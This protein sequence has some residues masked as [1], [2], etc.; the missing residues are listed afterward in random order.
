MRRAREEERCGS[1]ASSG[2]RGLGWGAAHMG[3]AKPWTL[4]TTGGDGC[5]LELWA[6]RWSVG[7]GNVGRGT[8]HALGIFPDGPWARRPRAGLTG[9]AGTAP[10]G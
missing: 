2:G 8:R 1:L 5:R 9:W 7:G 6:R 10:M 3:S 4:E